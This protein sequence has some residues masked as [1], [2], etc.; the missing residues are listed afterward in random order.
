MRVR[1]TASDEA[2]SRRGMVALRAAMRRGRSGRMVNA[3]AREAKIARIAAAR[4]ANGRAKIKRAAVRRRVRKVIMRAKVLLE[5][6]GQSRAA[7]LGVGMRRCMQSTSR[8]APVC[9]HAARFCR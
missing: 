7:V 8:S 3:V 1:R 9:R 6:V 5:S 4:R 2:V